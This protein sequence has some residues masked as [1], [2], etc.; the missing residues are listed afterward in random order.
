MSRIFFLFWVGL[1]VTTT[2]F[3]FGSMSLLQA[4]SIEYGKIT[5]TIVDEE[6]NA[7]PGVQ[8]D[9][10]SEA[11]ISGKRTTSS[12]ANGIYVFL[13]LPVGTYQ[14]AATLSGFKTVV[15]D[16]I[17]LSGGS[18]A[19]VDFQMQLGAVEESITVTENV[20]IVDKSSSTVD[21]KLDEEFLSRLPTSRE[22][23]YDTSLLSPG[24]FDMGSVSSSQP[25]PT[26]YG[27][28]TNENAFL[29][30]GVNATDPRGGSFGS[31]VNVNYDTVE[32]VRII[33][34]GAKA[35][36][37]SST[38][39][40]VDVTT[41]SGSNRF[42]G[43]GSV[44]SQL[45]KPSDNSPSVGDDLGRDWL[46]IDPNQ[47]LSGTVEKDREFSF[48]F[49]GPVVKDK[50][51]FFTALNALA[52]DNKSPLWPVTLENKDRYYDFKASA[53]PMKNHSAWLAYHLE[54]NENSGSTWGENVPWDSTLQYGAKNEERQHFF[55]VAMDPEF[56]K[57]YHCKVSWILDR[58]G[59]ISAGQCSCKSWIHQLV[60]MAR[61]WSERPLSVHRST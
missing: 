30:N 50:I 15:R 4:Q 14:A 33:S 8:V 45:G 3:S 5:G 29:V 53:E 44:Y 32:E 1:L 49:G 54:R 46:F 28:G 10:T 43:Q 20:P 41:K 39:V 27:S 59:S 56:Q 31:L 61:V 26:A 25:S 34:L 6:G 22:S 51:W 37:G 38:G 16:N 13:N 48:T 2:I 19:T 36:Y 42:H 47:Q 57:Y 17:E 52:E 55:S 11:L 40:A 7:V 21:S 24:M 9:V 18:V 60:E 58:L 35:E 23:F 12:S